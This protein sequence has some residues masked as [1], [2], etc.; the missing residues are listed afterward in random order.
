MKTPEELAEDCSKEVELCCG[1]SDIIIESKRAFLVGY[2]AGV[3]SSHEQIKELKDALEYQR[4]KVTELEKDDELLRNQID[5]MMN[6]KEVCD[7][8]ARITISAYHKQIKEL[9]KI[10]ANTCMHCGRKL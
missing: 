9:Q 3:A 6:G 8:E 2:N 7:E 1:T 5:Y 4:E 10:A